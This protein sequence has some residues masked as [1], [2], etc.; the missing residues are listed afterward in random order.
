KEIRR[1]EAGVR[2]VCQ[3]LRG[4]ESSVTGDYAVVTLP[5]GILA[6]I[7][8]DLSAEYK[9][10]ITAC[11]YVKAVKIAFQ[12]DRR[13][14]EEDQQ[15]YGGISWT[16]RDITQIWYPSAGFHGEKGVLLGA[17]IWTDQIGEQFGRLT[18]EQRPEAAL[19]SG[20]KL[21]PGYRL[22]VSRGVS[23]CW[24]KIPYS[25]GAWANWSAA[26]RN[27]SYQVLNQP[28]GPFHFAGEHLSF[29]TGWQEGAVLSA[30]N[31]V[32]AI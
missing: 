2:V 20:E 9:S 25:E 1:T 6:T 24:H 29:L 26:A 21:H 27:S 16:N 14:W 19:T 18:P 10:A 3:D 28:D 30:H 7:P 13:F 31:A 4:R 15:I 5:L 32:R 22:Q 17:Y 11:D 12:A 8:N 23:V